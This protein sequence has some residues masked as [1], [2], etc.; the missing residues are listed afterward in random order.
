VTSS[1]IFWSMRG[2]E[3]GIIV[4]VSLRLQVQG[5]ARRYRWR[6]APVPRAR[7]D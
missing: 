1:M 7:G 4:L 2:G 3:K 6:G 5:L